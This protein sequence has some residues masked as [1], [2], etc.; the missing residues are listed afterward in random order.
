MDGWK[1]GLSPIL[2]DFELKNGRYFIW[3][4]NQN[5]RF[6]R[7]LPENA[8]MGG[9]MAQVTGEG[10]GGWYSLFQTVRAL[11]DITRPASGSILDLVVTT[12]PV[13]V[14]DLSVHPGISDHNILTFTL[15]TSANIQAKPQR[16]I[17]QFQKADP[18]RLKKAAEDFS[19]KFLQTGSRKTIC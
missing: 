16:K 12:N 10:G 14:Q 19:T 5:E 13:L 9:K 15:S 17:Y 8:G 18:D 3:Q 2:G 1:K 11:R 6:A 7:N 4:S